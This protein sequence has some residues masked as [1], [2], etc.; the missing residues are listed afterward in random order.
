MNREE[1]M[2]IL[3]NNLYPPKRDSINQL[4]EFIDFIRSGKIMTYAYKEIPD[5]GSHT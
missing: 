5:A 3:F 1:F 4:L 2:S